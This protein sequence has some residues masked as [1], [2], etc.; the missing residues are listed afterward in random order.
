[1]RTF[2]NGKLKSQSINEEDYP[3]NLEDASE[4]NIKYPSSMD[5]KQKFALGHSLF[6]MM[7]GLFIYATIWLREHNRVCDILQDEFPD[8]SDERL[9]QTAKIILIGKYTSDRRVYLPTLFTSIGFIQY[10]LAIVIAI[11]MRDNTV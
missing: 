8:W 2:E 1:M 9:Y 4:V 3:P 5:G 6:G 11:D 7:S 10:E